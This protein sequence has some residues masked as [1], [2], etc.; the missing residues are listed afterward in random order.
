MENSDKNV[1]EL[2]KISEMM[3]VTQIQTGKREDYL[4]GIKLK[5]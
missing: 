2:L 4:G 5:N 3:G 1:N